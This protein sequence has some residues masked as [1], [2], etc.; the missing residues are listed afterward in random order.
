MNFKILAIIFIMALS[1]CGKN[2]VKMVK[3]SYIDKARTV[4]VGKS[5]DKRELCA[6]DK[7]ES[8]EDERGRVIVQY[9]CKISD[10]KDFNKMEREKYI[11]E[12]KEYVLNEIKDAKN[13][14]ENSKN[15]IKEGFPGIRESIKYCEARM[16]K[17]QKD[18]SLSE[19]EKR[20]QYGQCQYD[21]KNLYSRLESEIARENR[22]IDFQQE[23]LQNAKIKL[24]SN[25]IQEQAKKSYPIYAEAVEIFQWIVNDEGRVMLTYG[26]IQT[27]DANK[28]EETYI[29]YNR[30]EL[31]LDFAS[32]SNEENLEN[33]VRK[34]GEVAFANIFVR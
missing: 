21:L 26:E 8:F 29:K 1:G 24:D 14:I 16:E 9:S 34:M 12:K 4:K 3:N 20:M 28:K 15:K 27:R 2:P 19:S 6:K 33:Y 22:S 17:Y 11:Q 32:R 7:W 30:P 13:S 18:D 25:E 31:I 5:L 10:S 23:K